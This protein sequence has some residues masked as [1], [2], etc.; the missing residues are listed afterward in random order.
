MRRLIIGL[1][2]SLA[3]FG[4]TLLVAAC[5]DRPTCSFRCGSDNS[6]PYEYFCA[7]DG[8]CKLKGTADDHYCGEA[9]EPDAAPP[10]AGS[11]D[12]SPAK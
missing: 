1:V 12:A 6:C 9:P 7:T 2:L 3:L 5:Y 8:W 11:A 4:T 10:D